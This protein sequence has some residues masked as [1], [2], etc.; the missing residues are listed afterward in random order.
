MGLTALPSTCFARSFL[1]ACEEE[2]KKFTRLQHALSVPSDI[3]RSE[4]AFFVTNCSKW[5]M[6][7]SHLVLPPS[8]KLLS[9]NIHP[10]AIIVASVSVTT[11]TASL[12]KS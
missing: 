6:H 11:A 9:T 4:K 3:G 10:A 7:P 5:S 12:K 8:S 1:V 2:L